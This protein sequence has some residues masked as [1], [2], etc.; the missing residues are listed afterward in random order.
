MKSHI[1]L[2]AIVFL[3][4]MLPIHVFA[5]DDCDVSTKA[6]LKQLASNINISYVPNEIN[7][8]VTFTATINNVYPG[9]KIY[10]VITKGWFDHSNGIDNQNTI[11]MSGLN[12]GM[13]YRLDVYSENLDCGEEA[14]SVYYITLPDYNSF[15]KDPLCKG[16]EDYKLCGKW[17][18]HTLT[19]EQFT[20]EI[21]R[22]KQSLNKNEEKA[23]EKELKNPI[24]SF[25]TQY[26]YIF[27]GVV[28]I[29]GA[30]VAYIRNKKDSFGF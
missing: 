9:L 21:D 27:I 3:L 7:N 24:L 19:H 8:T 18:K 12:P 16:I 30:Y 15:Y 4:L 10:S 25:I 29:V 28:I 17:E 11:V 23:E 6:K 20:K 22:Y 2:S 1:K 14:L 13:S 26:Y 5:A